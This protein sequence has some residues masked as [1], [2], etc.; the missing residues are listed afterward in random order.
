MSSWAE[1]PLSSFLFSELVSEHF[2]LKPQGEM[3]SLSHQGIPGLCHQGRGCGS[4]WL[5]A[6]GTTDVKATSFGCIMCLFELM[7]FLV[8]PYQGPL[9][10]LSQPHGIFHSATSSS[11]SL[12]HGSPVPASER[13]IWRPLLWSPVPVHPMAGWLFLAY[14]PLYTLSRGYVGISLDWVHS[15]CNRR[16]LG[17][18]K[19]CPPSL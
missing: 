8:Q 7:V 16:K 4:G 19:L 2:V 17:K 9:V 3:R 15:R 13:C 5:S 10:Q 11:V 1:T 18:S 14:L 12:S 6:Q